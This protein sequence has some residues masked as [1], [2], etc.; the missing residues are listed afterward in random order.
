M[1]TYIYNID[2]HL[3]RRE[4]VTGS[5]FVLWEYPLWVLTQELAGIMHS[6]WFPSISYIQWFLL[7]QPNY[8]YKHIP[9]RIISDY[10]LPYLITVTDVY[11]MQSRFFFFMCNFFN[12]VLSFL[13]QMC[14]P[15]NQKQKDTKQQVAK[16]AGSTFKN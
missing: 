3:Q 1:Y 7:T 9:Y 14:Q 5:F 2:I 16:P 8:G 6:V 15:Q 13:P 12:S 10:T 4:N 11:T